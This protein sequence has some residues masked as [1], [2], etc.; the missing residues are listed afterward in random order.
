MKISE[1]TISVLR[2]VIIG[3]KL[4]PYRTGS[5][6]ITF[7]NQFG[8]DDRYTDGFPSRWCYAEEK[9]HEYNDSAVIK[10]INVASMGLTWRE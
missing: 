10:T 3:E 1:Q 7:F 4:S 8:A 2:S 9:L 5:Q 6:L